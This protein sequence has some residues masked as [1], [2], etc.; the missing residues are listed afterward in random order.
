LELLKRFVKRF[1]N[2][3]TETGIAA[4][5]KPLNETENLVG[6][7]G[8]RCST[9]AAEM[10]SQPTLSFSSSPELD[11]SLFVPVTP[12]EISQ[13]GRSWVMIDHAVNRSTAL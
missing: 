1:R 3:E 6:V 9:A 11:P 4:V 13:Q 7:V 2:S 10:A 5:S 12:L 8:C